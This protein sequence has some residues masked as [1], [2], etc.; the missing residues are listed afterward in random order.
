MYLY[1]LLYQKFKLITNKKSV[2][3]YTQKNNNPDTR[4]K[5]VI[6]SQEK[7]KKREGKK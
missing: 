6:K 1:R 3:T 7:K 5:I 2:M 4:V